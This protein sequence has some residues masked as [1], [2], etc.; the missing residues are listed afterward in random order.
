LATLPSLEVATLRNDVP[1]G[2]HIKLPEA[3]KKLML[4]PSLRKVYFLEGTLP[5]IGRGPSRGVKRC[6]AVL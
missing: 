4:S 5:G 1:E 3:L 6:H 2:S